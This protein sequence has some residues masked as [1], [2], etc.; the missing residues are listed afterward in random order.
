MTVMPYFFTRVCP[1]ENEGPMA[2]PSVTT[3]ASRLVM[4]PGG[5][6]P[7]PPLMKAA[8]SLGRSSRPCSVFTASQRSFAHVPRTPPLESVTASCYG[9]L[10]RSLVL[11]CLCDTHGSTLAPGPLGTAVGGGQLPLVLS[12]H[13]CVSSSRKQAPPRKVAE[14]ELKRLLRTTPPVTVAVICPLVGHF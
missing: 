13:M 4:L 2:R 10:L 5:R 11:P 12:R 6:T 9:S 1:R 14:K 3:P 8:V 7:S